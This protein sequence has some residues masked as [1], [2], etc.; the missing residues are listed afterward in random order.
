MAPAYAPGDPQKRPHEPAARAGT[1]KAMPAEVGHRVARWLLVAA[2]PTVSI[3]PP[4]AE[5]GFCH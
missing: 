3:D 5:K 1:P 2:N 4:G